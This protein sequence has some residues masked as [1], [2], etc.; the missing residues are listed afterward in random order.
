MIRRILTL[1]LFA[2][3][4]PAALILPA[5]DAGVARAQNPQPNWI[6]GSYTVAAGPNNITTRL[7]PALYRY[8]IAW[9]SDRPGGAGFMVSNGSAWVSDQG[10][11]GSAATLTLGTVST[12][13]AG[14][15]VIITNSGSSSAATFNFTIPRGDTG[16][17]GSNGSNGAAATIAA[18]TTTTGS[19]GT[20]A[21]VTNVGS[22]STAVFNFT[23]PRGDVGATGNTGATG[24]VGPS[25]ISSPNTRSLSL[26]T[27][28]QATDTSKPA[29]VTVVIE[30]TATVTI[31]SAQAN[32]M[33]LIVGST[34]GVA[35]GTGTL[36]DTFRS[37]LSVSIVIS[38][39]WTGRQTLRAQIPAG[40]FFAVR[41]TVGTGCSIISAHDQ[42]LG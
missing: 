10:A 28:Y 33:E 35:S 12:G 26:A 2:I 9:V 25:V 39:G 6:A 20:N 4:A 29:F 42:A 23:I 14:S 1:L 30:C 5:S 11:T 16:A 27:A 24:P 38:L 34:N 3:G 18:G 22:S 8:K 36:A 37:D 19:A 31:G 21:S 13:T 41:R 32:T 40:H 15:S 7:P 17:A